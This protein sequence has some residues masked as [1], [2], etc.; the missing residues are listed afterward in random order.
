MITSMLLSS[1]VCAVTFICG[2]STGKS[3]KE[4]EYTDQQKEHIV[5]F[6]NDWI[7]RNCKQGWLKMKPSTTAIT[8]DYCLLMVECVC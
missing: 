1:V 3:K 7:N 4:Q 5:Q 6:T 2:Y 8:D